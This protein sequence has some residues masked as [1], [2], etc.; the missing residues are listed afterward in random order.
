MHDRTCLFMSH[1]HALCP[2]VTSQVNGVHD[3]CDQIMCTRNESQGCRDWGKPGL[4]HSSQPTE[5]AGMRLGG[6][7]Y[8]AYCASL[9]GVLTQH[10]HGLTQAQGC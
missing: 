1:L 9:R 3:I 10:G 8:S 4:I 2:N 6:A 5:Q 7:V